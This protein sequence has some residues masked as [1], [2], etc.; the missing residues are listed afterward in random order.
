M[1][2]G[3]AFGL[4]VGLLAARLM[5]RDDGLGPGIPAHQRALYALGVAFVAYGAA[6]LPP[7]G[8]GFISV[9]VAA[10]TLGIR[11]PDVRGYF[12][13]RS[14]DVIELVKLGVF[15]VFGSLLTL[16]GLFG[17]GWAAVAIVAFTLLVARAL[18]V[19]RR[20]VALAGT[21]TDAFTRGFMAWFGPKGVATMTFSLLVLSA[22]LAAGERI[23]NLAALASTVLSHLDP[24]PRPD[25]HARLGVA[26]PTQRGPSEGAAR[27][28]DDLSATLGQACR[29]ACSWALGNA[30]LERDRASVRK[31][32]RSCRGGARPSGRSGRNV[33]QGSARSRAHSSWQRKKQ[34]SHVT[35][36]AF[37]PR[38]AICPEPPRRPVP[39]CE[40]TVI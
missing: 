36:R 12:A 8:N 17:D 11:R 1:T 31:A 38:C 15:V 34:S 32:K 7:A 16:E 29:A 30:Q 22:G 4:V 19:A 6:V 40:A 23:F 21:S 13:Q 33:A 39:L 5:P 25:G 2:L 28:G 10:I 35:F 20:F 24:G 37:P 27:A 18:R 26:G 9:F 14:E 3:L